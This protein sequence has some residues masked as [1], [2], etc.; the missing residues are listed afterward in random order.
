MFSY[1]RAV[2]DPTN[3]LSDSDWQL[4]TACFTTQSIKKNDYLLQTGQYCPVIYFVEQGAFRLFYET[5]GNERNRQ[6]FLEGSFM[7][8]MQALR[9][10]LPAEHA[11]QALEESTVIRF[12]RDAMLQLYRQIPGLETLGRELLEQLISDQQRQTDLY[13]RYSPTERYQRVVAEWPQLVQR[14]P[15]MHLASFLGVARETLSRIRKRY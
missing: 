15:L 7:T 3:G 9:T 14:I 10:Q 13:T 1:V 5:D 8:D 11:I 4:V 2:L 6:F 12:R